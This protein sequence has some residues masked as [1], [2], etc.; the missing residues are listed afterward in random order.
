MRLNLYPVIHSVRATWYRARQL[1]A[2]LWSAAITLT[3]ACGWLMLEFALR[4]GTE[5]VV[6]D[7]RIGFAVA[8]AGLLVGIATRARV[9]M[10][11]EL[12]VGGEFL[13][14]VLL[15]ISILPA[16]M[17][18]VYLGALIV[19]AGVVSLS[20]ALLGVVWILMVAVQLAIFAGLVMLVFA[21]IDEGAVAFVAGVIY[22]AVVC[23]IAHQSS[24]SFEN[25][26]NFALPR[27]AFARRDLI[28]DWIFA[29][30]ALRDQLAWLNHGRLMSLLL[31]IA[32]GTAVGFVA[33]FALRLLRQRLM[34]HLDIRRL[35]PMGAAPLPDDVPLIDRS[36]LSPLVVY[37]CIAWTAV[38]AW[39]VV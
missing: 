3:M 27:W 33:S 7:W 6:P 32:G 13:A 38:L 34:M 28:P 18:I 11:G 5:P 4:G 25:G 14:L 26:W 15:V 12:A 8:G 10:K 20:W 39:K 1:P 35:L 21:L 37:S 17:L 9:S 29:V 24:G 30:H 16:F 2:L 36:V 31:S 23:W 22:V 19:S